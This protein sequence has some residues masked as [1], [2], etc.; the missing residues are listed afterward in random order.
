MAGHVHACIIAL[1]GGRIAQPKPS[2]QAVWSH[3]R[4][5]RVAGGSDEHPRGPFP[6]QA[7]LHGGQRGGA[8][9]QGRVREL[10]GLLDKANMWTQ[11]LVENMGSMAAD[12]ATAG[13]ASGAAAP[14]AGA[15]RKAGKQGGR[16]AKKGAAAAGPLDADAKVGTHQRA[17][18]CA[19]NTATLRSLH[20]SGSQARPGAELFCL[21]HE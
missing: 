3:Q 21:T 2:C 18:P 8:L 13:E 15:K 5:R 10:E 7:A 11:F 19:C 17:A 14:A 9:E 6:A 1:T 16:A 12:K 20:P 4:S